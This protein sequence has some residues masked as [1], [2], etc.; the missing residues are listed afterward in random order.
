MIPVKKILK[1]IKNYKPVIL[2]WE[3]FNV[4]KILKKS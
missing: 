2:G 1:P 3:I 4:I